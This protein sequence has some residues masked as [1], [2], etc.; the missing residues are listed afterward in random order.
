MEQ[1]TIAFNVREQLEFLDGGTDLAELLNQSRPL[2]FEDE[3]QAIGIHRGLL[4]QLLE[5]L[6]ADMYGLSSHMLYNREDA[7]RATQEIAAGVI[8]HLA[9]FDFRSKLKAW[10]YRIA[11]A[12]SWM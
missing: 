8:T 5:A 3:A 4:A 7:E 1:V 6:Q 12:V 11:G 9:Q 10:A 2:A